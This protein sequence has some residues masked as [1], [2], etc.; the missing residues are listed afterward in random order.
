MAKAK[1][2]PIKKTIKKNSTKKVVTKKQIIKASTSKKIVKTKSAKKI[3]EN[4]LKNKPVDWKSTSIIFGTIVIFIILGLIYFN[5]NDTKNETFQI[6]NGT[7]LIILEDSNCTTCGVDLFIKQVKTNLINDLEVHKISIDTKEG[8]EIINKLKIRQVPVYLFGKSIE[9][10]TDWLQLKSAFNNVTLG[11]INFYQLKSQIVQNKVLIE[12]P[13][14]LDNSVVYGDVNAPVTIYEFS[15]FECP[16]C[17]IAEGNVELVNKFKEKNPNYISA[18]P[19]I[20]EKYIKTGKVKLVFYNMPIEKL[21]PQVRPVHLASLC[22][23]EQGKW[24]EFKEL[25]FLNRTDWIGTSSLNLKLKDYAK[26]LGLDTNKFN[27]CLDSKKYND[28]IN[29]EINYGISLGV[30]GTPT[31][32]IGRNF[33]SGAQDFRTFQYIIENKLATLK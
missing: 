31:F 32:F 25:A 13:Q 6:Q 1:K 20:F 8:K 15:D 18:M 14:I 30:S 19:Q 4:S 10:R 7:S 3:S 27:S 33:L 17:A 12:E 23:N 11:G 21:H 29:N 24:Y 16:F 5:F 2:K 28:Q 22:A 9:K 26:E